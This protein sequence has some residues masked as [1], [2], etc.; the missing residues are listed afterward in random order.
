MITGTAQI[1]KSEV[2]MADEETH[3]SVFCVDNEDRF[4]FD[5]KNFDHDIEGYE[6][7]RF[8]ANKLGCQVTERG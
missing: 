5:L 3:F 1:S 2:I 8:W 6:Y 7:A 4:V